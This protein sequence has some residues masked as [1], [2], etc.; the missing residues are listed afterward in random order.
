MPVGLLALSG[1]LFWI[2]RVTGQL[3]TSQ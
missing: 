3:K 1:T 2:D